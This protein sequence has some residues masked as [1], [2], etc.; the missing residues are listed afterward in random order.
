MHECEFLPFMV[1]NGKNRICNIFKCKCGKWHYTW[2]SEIIKEP[3]SEE[4][5]IELS[6]SHNREYEASI[7]NGY[8]IDERGHRIDVIPH[9][10]K[11]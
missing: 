4:S 10:R 2:D 3:A 5:L 8:Y 11:N 6:K 9:K 1:E 7:K